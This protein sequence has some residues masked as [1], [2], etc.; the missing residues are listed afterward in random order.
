MQDCD[1]DLYLAIGV[2]P[3]AGY[4]LHAYVVMATRNDRAIPPLAAG[5][6]WHHSR[7]H[8]NSSSEHR[9]TCRTTSQALLCTSMKSVLMLDMAE[10]IQL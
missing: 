2:M 8:C 6:E 3:S 1:E 10:S 7:T 9:R 5:A 4:L